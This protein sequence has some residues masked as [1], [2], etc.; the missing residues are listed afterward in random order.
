MSEDIGICKSCN[1][2]E[3]YEHDTWWRYKTP[4]SRRLSSEQPIN[5]TI[6]RC[7]NEDCDEFSYNDEENEELQSGYPC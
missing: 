7:G 1:K 6:Y 4:F 2:G 3:L 5:G